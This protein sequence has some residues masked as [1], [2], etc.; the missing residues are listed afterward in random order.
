MLVQANAEVNYQEMNK[1]WVHKKSEK[2]DQFAKEGT[3]IQHLTCTFFFLDVR[4]DQLFSRTP[5]AFMHCI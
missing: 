3:F 2:K 4:L 1:I 5:P